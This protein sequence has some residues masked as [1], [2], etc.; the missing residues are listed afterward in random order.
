MFHHYNAPYFW[1]RPN[2]VYL[3][4]DKNHNLL[5]FLLF[6]NLGYLQEIFTFTLLNSVM[7][8]VSNDKSIHEFSSGH[9]AA[10]KAKFGQKRIAFVSDFFYPNIGGVE[11]HIYYLAKALI[12]RGHHVI[13]ITHCYDDMNRGLCYIN[14]NHE[15][16]HNEMEDYLQPNLRVYY[17]PKIVVFDQVSLPMIYATLPKLREILLDENIGIVHGHQSSSMFDVI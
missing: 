7:D 3:T 2:H 9:S 13:V 16:V 4:L 6:N 5:L 14:S 11:N 1:S 8:T 15:V 12:D 10:L 17:I